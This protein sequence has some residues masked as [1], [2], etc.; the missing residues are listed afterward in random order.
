MAG[1]QHDRPPAQE[2][3]WIDQLAACSINLATSSGRE[4]CTGRI[5]LSPWMHPSHRE[6]VVRTLQSIPGCE[7]LRV[8]RSTLV[9]SREWQ[10][11]TA[12]ARV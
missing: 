11:L 12:K 6:S 5:T 8:N 7:K 4:T 2:P 3:D 9:G 1:D 10:A